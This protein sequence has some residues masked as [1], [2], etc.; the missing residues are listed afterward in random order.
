MQRPLKRVNTGS[1][2]HGVHMVFCDCKI[3]FQ[4]TRE[5]ARQRIQQSPRR[6]WNSR[7]HASQPAGTPVPNAL[8][9]TA[10]PTCHLSQWPHS[11]DSRSIS[12]WPT[13]ISN[14]VEVSDEFSMCSDSSYDTYANS[15]ATP[16]GPQGGS[17]QAKTFTDRVGH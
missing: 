17:S 6:A 7:P 11:P 12:L 10:H 2:A 15:T 1:Q 5:W 14:G 8:Q 16:G 4:G 9:E 3:E 13:E